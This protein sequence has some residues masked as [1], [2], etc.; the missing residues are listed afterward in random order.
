MMHFPQVDTRRIGEDLKARSSSLKAW[1]L[2]K[3]ASSVAPEYVW[4]NIGQSMDAQ[5]IMIQSV[6][7]VSLD[8]DPVPAERRN[9]G[10]WTFIGYWFSDLADMY[11]RIVSAICLAILIILVTDGRLALHSLLSG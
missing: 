11:V 10:S 5:F 9:W 3:Q 8:Q 1:E 4:S 7:T 6:L 2:P